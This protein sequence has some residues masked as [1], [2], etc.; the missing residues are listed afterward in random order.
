MIKKPKDYQTQKKLLQFMG[1]T[2]IAS[3]KRIDLYEFSGARGNDP[4][5]LNDIAY[6]HSIDR[7]LQDCSN[8]TK[9]IIRHD[10]LEKSETGWYRVFYNP[11]SYYRLKRRAVEEFMHCL[12]I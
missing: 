1:D 9:N 6:V 3:K 7:T 12:N 11:S 4:S 8:D 2:Y 5:Y 10:F